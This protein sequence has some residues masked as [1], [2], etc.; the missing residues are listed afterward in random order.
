LWDA[1]TRVRL[2]VASNASPDDLRTLVDMRDG[3]VHA[4]QEAELEARIMTA[5]VQHA[6]AL[7]TDLGRDRADFWAEQ[8]GVVDALLADATDKV[9][10][11]VAIRLAHAEARYAH[12]YGSMA[13][14]VARIVRAAREVTSA[15]LA[16]DQ[17]VMRCPVC[18]SHGIAIGDFDVEFGDPDW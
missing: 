10:P 8:L 15:A 7:L 3:V 17:A 1:L 16:S 2:F 11:R 12:E 5:F 9:A 18:E 14:T 6:D 4:A 13:P